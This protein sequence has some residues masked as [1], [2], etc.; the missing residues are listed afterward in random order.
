MT[1]KTL[2]DILS[3]KGVELQKEGSVTRAFCPFHN[4]T[5]R[6]NFTVYPQT[7]SWF[8]FACNVGGDAAAFLAKF[9]KISYSE[10]KS[11]VD[12]VSINLDTLR[13]SL[14]GLLVPNEP[15]KMNNEL[16]VLIS[17]VVRRHLQKYPDRLQAVKAVLKEFDLKLLLPINATK[18]TAILQ[19]IRT[20]LGD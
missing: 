2:L 20:K 8:C 19:E 16:N 14:D 11:K 3:E 4:D 5:G 15:P 10:A 6:P 18:M 17:K 13:E 1:E 7:D 9:D 12:G